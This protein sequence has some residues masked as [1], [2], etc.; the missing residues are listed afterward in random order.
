VQVYGRPKRGVA[1]NHPG[2]RC[3]R[4]HVATWAET[5]TVPAA[6]LMAGNQDPRGHAAELPNRALAALPAAARGG[7]IGPRADAG[8]FA[9][10]LARA[11]LRA[12]VEFAIGAKRIAALWRILHGVAAGAWTDAIDTAAAQVAGAGRDPVAD[13]PGAARRGGRAGPR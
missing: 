11:A 5:A 6:D 9:G 3:G 4:P 13:R 2:Q 7:R 10:Q 1:F 12:G 8:C